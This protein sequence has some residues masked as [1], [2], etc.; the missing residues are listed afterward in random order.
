[1]NK[2]AER[3]CW[4]TPEWSIITEMCIRNKFWV[5]LPSLVIFPRNSSCL[6]N[7]RVN[8]HFD[9]TFAWLVFAVTIRKE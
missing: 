4:L 6:E 9:L 2:I 7:G 8:P 3:V 1:M 5:V